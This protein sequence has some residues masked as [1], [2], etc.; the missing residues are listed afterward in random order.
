ML[1]P[2]AQA[3]LDRAAVVPEDGGLDLGEVLGEALVLVGDLEGKLASVAKDQDGNLVLTG[4]EGAG[5]GRD[6]W[7]WVRALW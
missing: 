6:G 4:G 3:H 2:A 5:V 7:R 1:H